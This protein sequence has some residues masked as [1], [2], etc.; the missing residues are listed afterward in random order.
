MATVRRK[1]KQLYYFA[2][3]Y[4]NTF[5]LNSTTLVINAGYGVVTKF[6]PG[7][8]AIDYKSEVNVGDL[9]A[10]MNGN[11]FLPSKSSG[12]SPQSVYRECRQTGKRLCSITFIKPKS[13]VTG[14]IFRPLNQI[15]IDYQQWME[16][17]LKQSMHALDKKDRKPVQIPTK[18][19]DIKP[20]LEPN[21]S[22][23]GSS[24]TFH[25][26]HIGTYNVGDYGGMARIEPLLKKAIANRDK[27]NH[28]QVLLTLTDKSTIIR[29]RENGKE[30]PYLCH[31]YA[32]ISSCGRLNSESL[33]F[34]YIAGDTFCSISTNFTGYVFIAEDNRDAE[35]ILHG[36]YQ[37]FK[38]TTWFM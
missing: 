21:A 13:L 3:I 20:V 36:I 1:P 6:I 35:Q 4:L 29:T 16:N 25:A 24:G 8:R 27:Y 19:S 22:D 33:Y 28:R 31:K 5:L 2:S 10:E 18:S 15:V 11:T 9:I 38:H 34:C 30:T 23:D 7:G 37:G 32:D 14:N 17:H 26:T 12:P